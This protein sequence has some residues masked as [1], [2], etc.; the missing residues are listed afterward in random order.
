MV[1]EYYIYYYSDEGFRVWCSES[2][3]IETMTYA[4]LPEKNKFIMLDGYEPNDTSLIQ[5]VED[6]KI[7]NHELMNNKILSIDFTSYYNNNLAVFRIFHRLSKGKYEDHDEIDVIEAR[8][9]DRTYNA[10]LIYCKPQLTYSCSLDYTSFYPKIFASKSFKMP[11]KKGKEIFINE[12]PNI[13]KIPFGFYR[14]KITCD[15][16]DFRKIFSFSKED[17]YLHNS[18][19]I[20]LKYK[21]E[22]KVNIELIKD[23]EPNAYLYELQEET[24][25]V[26]GE[27]IF[28]NWYNTLEKIKKLYPKNR[29]LKFLISSLSGQLTRRCV[30]KKTYDEIMDEKLDVGFDDSHKYI[31]RD[32]K[33]YGVG[34]DDEKYL[35]ME[36]TKQ[37]SHKFRLMPFLTATARNKTARLALH[38]LKNVVRIHTDSVC[39]NRKQEFTK[40]DFVLDYESLKVEEKNTGVILWKNCNKRI[41]YTTILKEMKSGM[42]DIISEYEKIIS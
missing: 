13:A 29:L 1:K 8:W 17:T 6:F 21:D 12:L 28:G 22:F 4:N 25:L 20:A 3:K 36:S 38:D 24:C 41:N 42:S 9:M 39:F 26:T 14:V 31:I 18:L 5:F 30:F 33:S 15:N 34:L 19:Y 32:K 7:W 2:G 11:T 10:A 23:N 40:K 16:D 37:Y 35:L 27:S